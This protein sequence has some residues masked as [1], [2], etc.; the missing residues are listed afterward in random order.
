[1]ALDW[2][3]MQ[4]PGYMAT[5]DMRSAATDIGGAMGYLATQGLSR[6]DLSAKTVGEGIRGQ[7]RSFFKDHIKG[8]GDF[9]NYDEWIASGEAG[10]YLQLAEAGASFRKTPEGE[11]KVKTPE[12]K[13][14]TMGGK[15]AEEDALWDPYYQKDDIT[16][17][18]AHMQG[19]FMG[20][21]WT[22]G[23][24]TYRSSMNP[25]MAFFNREKL[26]PVANLY[27]DEAMKALEANKSGTIDWTKLG[28]AKGKLGLIGNLMNA[29][30]K[31]KKV[32]K[33]G[34]KNIEI[35]VDTNTK[36]N[37]DVV[38]GD[39]VNG[40]DNNGDDNNGGAGY[41]QKA[42]YQGLPKQRHSG[43]NQVGT[44][45]QSNYIM[46]TYKKNNVFRK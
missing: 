34:N 27:Y 20:P 43:L 39:V 41:R 12:G 6:H 23:D 26:R 4:I 19:Q 25:L 29:F 35:I 40:D 17:F 33:N 11:W 30:K 9:K 3:V 38:N 31:D 42:N 37:G 8:Q 45:N 32:A 22:G 36:K 15:G 16:D 5:Q 44:D 2:S 13:W 28:E 1:M 14:E 10:R 21:D 24:Y 18:E 7:G 46:P